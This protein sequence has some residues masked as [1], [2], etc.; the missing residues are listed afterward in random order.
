MLC[1]ITSGNHL[2]PE[3]PVDSP[4]YF[5]NSCRSMKLFKS[6]FFEPRGKKIEEVLAKYYQPEDHRD[7]QP[8]FADLFQLCEYYTQHYYI[9]WQF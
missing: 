2:D 9:G 5:A 6:K 4:N 1:T 3:C 8:S 7:T